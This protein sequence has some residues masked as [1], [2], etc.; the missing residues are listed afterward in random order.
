MSAGRSPASTLGPEC[1]TV[2]FKIGPFWTSRDYW[3]YPDAGKMK[4][5]TL[6][7]Y[8]GIFTILWGYSPKLTFKKSELK[9]VMGH[10]LG[11]QR[12]TW[13]HDLDRAHQDPFSL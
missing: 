10:V 3:K 11:M 7:K 12:Q 1:A 5:G 9:T 2:A 13:D 8:V 6:F 4:V